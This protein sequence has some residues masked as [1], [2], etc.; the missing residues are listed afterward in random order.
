MRGIAF[1]QVRDFYP[2]QALAPSAGGLE[3]QRD[4]GPAMRALRAVLS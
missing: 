4:S 2:E 1:T 3:A